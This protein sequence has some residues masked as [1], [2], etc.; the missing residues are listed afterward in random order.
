MLTN[1][2]VCAGLG[3]IWARVLRLD[4][5][6]GEAN[7]LELGGSSLAAVHIAAL[8]QERYAVMLDFAD[9]FN[10]EDLNALAT[11]VHNRLS[12]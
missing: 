3:E 10:S 2:D 9:V 4:A 11:L 5:V 6:P 1:D 7:F 8:V 12:V